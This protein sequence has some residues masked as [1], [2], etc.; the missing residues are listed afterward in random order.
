MMKLKP[1]V[2]VKQANTMKHF[3]RIWLITEDIK[4]GVTGC[5]QK[6]SWLMK[7]H[8]GAQLLCDDHKA[9]EMTASI[10]QNQPFYDLPPCKIDIMYGDEEVE[11]LP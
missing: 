10:Q 9:L 2:L 7:S 8:L 1:V 4:C 6:S 5:F 11:P 3:S